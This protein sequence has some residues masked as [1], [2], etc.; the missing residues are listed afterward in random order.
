MAKPQRSLSPG[1]WAAVLCAGL[2]I[3]AAVAA[4][5]WAGSSRFPRLEDRKSVV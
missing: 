2:L 4:G 1:K 5:L 3:L